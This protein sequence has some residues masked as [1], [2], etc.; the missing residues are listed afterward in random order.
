MRWEVSQVTSA[1]NAG[2]SQGVAA[3]A[4]RVRLELDPLV[5]LANTHG[6]SSDNSYDKRRFFLTRCLTASL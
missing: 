5:F 6:L 1:P 3:L 2:P 4:R